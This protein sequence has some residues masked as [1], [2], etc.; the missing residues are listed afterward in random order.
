MVSVAGLFTLSSGC[1]RL[2]RRSLTLALL[3]QLALWYHGGCVEILVFPSRAR[4]SHSPEHSPFADASAHPV[5]R[6][7]PGHGIPQPHRKLPTTPLPCRP[8]GLRCQTW[9]HAHRRTVGGFA[10][11]PPLRGCTCLCCTW[12][13]NPIAPLTGPCAGVRTRRPPPVEAG[14]STAPDDAASEP[15]PPSTPRSAPP[16]GPT[17]APDAW[18]EVLDRDRGGI[19]YWNKATNETTELHAPPPE[20]FQLGGQSFDPN[21]R[22]AVAATDN[23]VLGQADAAGTAAQLESTTAGNVG[24]ADKGGTMTAGGDT[25]APRE[26]EN[27]GQ[28]R[29]FWTWALLTNFARVFTAPCRPAH[30]AWRAR[31]LGHGHDMLRCAFNLM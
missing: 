7:F 19:Y 30:A 15:T 1:P 12:P 24:E 31:R 26:L 3:R 20:G 23:A 8:P 5:P 11:S 9:R 17:S 22:F 6:P 2:G 25:P 28:S 29:V 27:Q 4:S 13:W 14:R 16:R 21:P 10:R 18:V